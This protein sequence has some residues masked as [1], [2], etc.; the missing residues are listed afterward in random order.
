MRSRLMIVA[1][2]LLTSTAAFS[3]SKAAFAA[4]TSCPIQ[5]GDACSVGCP[6]SPTQWCDYLYHHFG[7]E[8]SSAE[9][10]GIDYYQC[11]PEPGEGTCCEMATGEGCGGTAPYCASTHVVCEFY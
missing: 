7:C 11:P 5:Y 9:C 3:T 8:T 2:S 4:A 10:L 1:I 6:L